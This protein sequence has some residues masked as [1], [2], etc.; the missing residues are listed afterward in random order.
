MNHEEENRQ[1]PLGLVDFPVSI[2]R[3]GHRRKTNRPSAVGVSAS[4]SGRAQNEGTSF[5]MPFR[6]GLGRHTWRSLADIFAASSTGTKFAQCVTDNG[7]PR[8]KAV[9]YRRNKPLIEILR[10]DIGCLVSQDF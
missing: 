1:A 10:K 2:I 8:P 4:S 9:K 7:T 6:F 5:W 3:R